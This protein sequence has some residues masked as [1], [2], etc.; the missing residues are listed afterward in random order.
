MMKFR[1]IL[2]KLTPTNLTPLMGELANLDL[3]KDCGP[4]ARML[5]AKS[6]EEIQYQELFTTI[7]KTKRE[8][9]DEIIPLI[10]KTF[11]NNEVEKKHI[12]GTSKMLC[13]L[14]MEGLISAARFSE[15]LNALMR[16]ESESAVDGICAIAPFKHII[17]CA[18]FELLKKRAAEIGE[19]ADSMR[20]KFLVEDFIGVQENK[21]PSSPVSPQTPQKIIKQRIPSACTVY[22]SNIDCG[23]TEWELSAL[24]RSFGE[25]SRVRLCGNPRQATQYAFVEFANEESSHAALAKDGKCLLGKFAL[26]WSTSKSVIQDSCPSDAIFGKNGREKACTFGLNDDATPNYTPLRFSG[27]QQL[28]K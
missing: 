24:L 23:V 6:L 20:V 28:Q 19:D 22:L 2:N 27:N 10:E 18:Q 11:A 21:A 25:L 17:S 15:L 1:G 3:S 4:C 12:V 13:N 16:N 7:A 9:L 5:W 14:R 8:L 26:R